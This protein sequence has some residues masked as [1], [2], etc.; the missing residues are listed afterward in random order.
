MSTSDYPTTFTSVQQ[1]SAD[2]EI[3]TVRAVRL[4]DVYRQSWCVYA[5]DS[6][7]DEVMASLPAAER[8]MI[9]A[10]L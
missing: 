7:P 3:E 9:A 1:F 5:I 2:G 6:I 8:A 10:K 4:W